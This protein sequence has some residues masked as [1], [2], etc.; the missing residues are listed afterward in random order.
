MS[1]VV[2]VFHC[3]YARLSFSG[4]I[5]GMA[6]SQGVRELI[7]ESKKGSERRDIIRQSETLHLKIKENALYYSSTYSLKKICT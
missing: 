2:T 1:G 6:C 4:P 7:C 3:V 5:F